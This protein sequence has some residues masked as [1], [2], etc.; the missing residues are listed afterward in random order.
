M[1]N[2]ATSQ[3]RFA[4]LDEIRGIAALLVL[5]AHSLD[6]IPLHYHSYFEIGNFGVILFFFCSGFII[7]ISVERQ[8]LRVFW[9]RRFFRLYP[10]YWAS[11][12]LA[13][14]IG[15]AEV[16]TGPAILANLTM[17]QSVLGFPNIS[18]VY[19]SLTVEMIFY[20]IASVLALLGV[21]RRT[22]A[23]MLISGAAVIFLHLAGQQFLAW[24]GYHIPFMFMGT[25]YYRRFT[26]EMSSGTLWF[27]V[28]CLC[29]YI[30]LFNSMNAW[31]LAQISAIGLFHLLYLARNSPKSWFFVAC[32]RISYSIYLIH[33]LALI[34]P[35][36]LVVR[37]L[38]ALLI[39]AITY[40]LIEQ[41]AINYG[42]RIT[43]QVMFK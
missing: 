8:S 26:Q 4:W 20:I 35:V 17:M 12:A 3:A 28:G 30:L 2:Q 19:W 33:P 36:P 29:L 13:L 42:R 40:R 14:G 1:N 21:T 34:I 38:L 43:Q 24:L 37:I 10:L 7:P 6:T 15:I 18:G 39:A 11:I 5:M 41:P 31:A 16:K 32:G 22:V 23:S 27:L 9:L 25:A